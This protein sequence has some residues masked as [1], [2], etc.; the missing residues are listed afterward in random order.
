M[1]LA[2]SACAP[3]T[4][5]S[6]SQITIAAAANLTEAFGE[7]GTAFEADSGIHVVHSF[8][9]TGDLTRQIENAAPFDVFAAADVSHVQELERKDLLTVNTRVVYARGRLAVWAAP[10][11]ALQLNTLTDLTQPA[12]RFIAIAKPELAP[13]GSAAVEV[14]QNAGIW[15]QVKPKVVYAENISMAKQY[16]A[17][18]NADA[19][20]TAY[21]LVM[22]SGGSVLLVDE[23]LHAPIDQALAVVK[24]SPHQDEAQQYRKFVLGDKG[25]TILERYGY[26]VPR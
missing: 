22:R 24:R 15:E 7:I 16:A 20:F 8:A 13:Y 25:R 18:R 17:T 26:Q 10:G 14:L 3:K 6:K 23:K 5:P 4:P 1:L 19:S 12:V 9:S 2:F 11:S 21:S